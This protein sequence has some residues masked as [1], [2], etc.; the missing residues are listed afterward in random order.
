MQCLLFP[1]GLGL[2]GFCRKLE[3]ERKVG[4]ALE[5]PGSLAVSLHRILLS[6]GALLV[7]SGQELHWLPCRPFH[8]CSGCAAVGPEG[9]SVLGDC[10]PPSHCF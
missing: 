6:P 1:V 9:H 10:P 8:G 3:E 7:R 5:A 2:W 4:L